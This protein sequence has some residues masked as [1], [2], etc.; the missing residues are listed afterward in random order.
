MALIGF[1]V[2]ALFWIVGIFALLHVAVGYLLLRVAQK[3]PQ[4]EAQG[5]GFEGGLRWLKQGLLE[6][7][8]TS[9]QYF[10]Y[11]IAYLLAYLPLKKP[12][13]LKKDSTIPV[14]FIPGYCGHRLMGLWLSRTWKQDPAIGPVYT[15]NLWPPLASIPALAEHLQH[16]V[17]QILAETGST[18]VILVAHSMGG[19]VASYMAE[20]LAQPGEI[21]KIISL[22]T[23]F[24]GTW[25]A[26]L[27]LGENAVQMCPQSTFLHELADRIQDS[28]IPYYCI[29]SRMDNQII[30]WDSAL[31]ANHLAETNHLIL[32]D[33]GHVGLLFSPIVINQISQWIKT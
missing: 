30:P 14:V 17:R 10:S 26:T 15:I 16:Q 29:A 33:Q 19:L 1:L 2:K 4:K 20:Y 7:C 28:R 8:Y 31:F 11:P 12:L 18:R 32:E 23:P 3:L 13:S 21:A 6:A 5:S 24:A 22:G 9:L 25:L 27:G